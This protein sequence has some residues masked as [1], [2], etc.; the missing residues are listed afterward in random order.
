MNRKVL[1]LVLAATMGLSMA[2]CGTKE[3]NDMLFLGK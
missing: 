3:D 2:A 1:I